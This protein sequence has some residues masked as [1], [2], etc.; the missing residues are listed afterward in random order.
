MKGPVT[1]GSHRLID[2]CCPC[3]WELRTQQRPWFWRLAV[4]W[5]GCV[6]H[7]T[8]VRCPACKG[9]GR[10]R[11]STPRPACGTCGGTGRI[12][13]TPGPSRKTSQEHNAMNP[14][15]KDGSFPGGAR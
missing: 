12:T 10:K 13:H 4:I 5:P 15:P 14:T 8:A 3:D 6:I 2:R 11:P 1:A 7:G 9:T